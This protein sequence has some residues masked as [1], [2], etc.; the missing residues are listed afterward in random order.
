MHQEFE[1]PSSGT[2]VVCHI[3]YALHTLSIVTGIMT[4]ASIVGAFIFSIP[5]VVAVVL[6]YLL[7]ADARGTV[8]ESH[9]VWQIRTFWSALLWVLFLTIFGMMTFFLGG[10]GF[11]VLFAGYFVL[12]IW[13]VWRIA[14]GW[15][16]LVNGVPMFS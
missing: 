4:A 8:L 1:Q 9:F 12:G 5:S 7:R 16:N 10:L 11:V 3:V 15:L 6:N 14:R 2:T 13:V